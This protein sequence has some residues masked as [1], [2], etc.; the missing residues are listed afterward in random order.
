MNDGVALGIGN[1]GAKSDQ[2]ENVLCADSMK[3]TVPLP[4]L[5]KIFVTR[6]VK[7]LSWISL[8]PRISDLLADL[9]RSSTEVHVGLSTTAIP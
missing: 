6:A 4:S 5:S 7:G 1:S 8:T 3:E 2:Q 9:F